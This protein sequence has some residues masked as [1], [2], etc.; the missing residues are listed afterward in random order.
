[1]FVTGQQLQALDANQDGCFG[2][3]IK[4]CTLM[5][6]ISS[7]DWDDQAKRVVIRANNYIAGCRESIF[8]RREGAVGR[9]MAYAEFTFGTI[10]QRV[11]ASPL[12]VRLHYGHPDVF[13]ALMLRSDGVMSKASTFNLNEDIFLFLSLSR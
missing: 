6:C 3:A 8:T 11:L 13:D 7:R 12:R 1:M 5:G 2:E 4:L 10:F 9:F